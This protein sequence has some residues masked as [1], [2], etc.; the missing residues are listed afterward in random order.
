[1][2]VQINNPAQLDLISSQFPRRDD[3]GLAWSR[4]I[5]SRLF[6]PKTRGFWPFSLVSG[7]NDLLDAT[8][9]AGTGANTGAVGFDLYGVSPYG[10]FSGSNHFVVTSG[11]PNKITGALTMACVAYMENLGVEQGFM[12][13]WG[14]AGNRSYRMR[15][16]AS[17]GFIFEVSSDGT[18][19]TSVTSTVTPSAGPW[20]FLL[21]EYNPS[22]SL[23]IWVNGTKTQNTTSIPASIFD[24]TVDLLLGNTNGS[25]LAG[26]MSLASLHASTINSGIALLAL[27]FIR[28]LFAIAL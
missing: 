2:T 17:N 15:I 7:D 11:K 20:Y 3:T 9:N 18:A 10:V 28:P 5:S 27:D 19:V 12:S 6:F 13:K 22:T 1:M 16:T 26:G 21:A 24:S 4:A 14:S 23:T 25:F 8:G